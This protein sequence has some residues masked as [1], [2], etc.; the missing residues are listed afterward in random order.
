MDRCYARAKCNEATG[1][2]SAATTGR[3]TDRRCPRGDTYCAQD[4]T[5]RNNAFFFFFSKEEVDRVKR[6]TEQSKFG[7]PRTVARAEAFPMPSH[8]CQPVLAGVKD[9]GA[10]WPAGG[11]G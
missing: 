2:W 10:R 11:G 6:R 1:A 5:W 9:G 7:F 4:S 8:E 3:E